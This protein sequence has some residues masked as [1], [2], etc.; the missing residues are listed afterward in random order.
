MPKLTKEI[1]SGNQ[2]SRSSNEG[3]L[4]DAA[5]RVF[6]IVLSEPNESFDI[7]QA[8]GIKIG[9][10][11]PLNDNV[12]CNLISA[13][14][15][16]DSRLVYVVTFQYQS[17]A[18]QASSGGGGDQDPKNQPPN[19]RPC[20]WTTSTSLAEVPK[21]V[22]AKRTGVNGGWAAEEPAVNPVGDMYD[23]V[24]ALEPVT[25]I[26]ITQ[27]QDNDPTRLI[28]YAGYV[29]E[30][31]V[32]LG[33]LVMT[34]G[35]VLFRGI[36]SQPANEFWGDRLFRGWTTTFEFAYRRNTTK[37]GISGA[38]LEADIGWDIAIPVTGFNVRAFNPANAAADEDVFGQ[39][40]RHGPTDPDDPDF[41]PEFA[42]R[43]IDDP[44]PLLPKGT[45]AG[46]R[47]RAMVK[48]F[49]Y[50]GGGT[51]QLPSAQP[52]PLKLNGRPLKTHDANGN[53]IN[54]PLVFAYRVQPTV[55]F[56]N[57][58]GIRTD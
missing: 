5:T 11:H 46:D 16:G 2:V 4:A 27:F 3:Q 7:Q 47:V 37:V 53:L 55:N 57:T 48:V 49:S 19:I 42:G 22:W 12:T 38:N 56:I 25:T 41:D 13:Q 45:L 58:F 18:S 36:S 40:L 52:V 51:S 9:D 35:T 44:A 32:N 24:T 29:N 14:F 43:I 10:K 21:A 15:E 34:P 31:T 54:R 39:P 23:G 33:N 20:N 6:R 50:K 30:E 28:R 8:C 17:T 1:S 26:S